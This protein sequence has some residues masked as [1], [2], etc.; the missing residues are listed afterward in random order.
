SVRI[1]VD[2]EV[3]DRGVPR[4]HAPDNVVRRSAGHI[5]DVLGRI[6]S[7]EAFEHIPAI[8]KQIDRDVR[9]LTVD[10]HT[11]VIDR[12]YRYGPAGNAVDRRTPRRDHRTRP[13]INAVAEIER[14]TGHGRQS[15]ET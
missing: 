7:I 2:N 15:E 4:D 9:T 3:P 14:V 10:R 13:S 6:M 8:A 12:A 1:F 5:N 11:A